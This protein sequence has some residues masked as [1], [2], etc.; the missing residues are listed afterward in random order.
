MRNLGLNDIDPDVVS[1]FEQKS[2]REREAVYDV[3][4][5]LRSIRDG[6]ATGIAGLF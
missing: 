6:N 1:H 4:S 2:G 3:Q 5:F